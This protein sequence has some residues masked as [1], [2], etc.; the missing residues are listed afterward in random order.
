M[1]E[2]LI[3]VDSSVLAAESAVDHILVGESAVDHVSAGE[4]VLDHVTPR[5]SHT[6]I[7]DVPPSTSL[8]N[9]AYRELYDNNVTVFLLCF[10]SVS[11]LFL[12]SFYSVFTVFLQ[13]FYSVFTVF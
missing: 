11:T 13:C 10:Y 6:L 3:A 5:S 2:D 8:Q 1:E 12:Q 4:H 9:L 7:D